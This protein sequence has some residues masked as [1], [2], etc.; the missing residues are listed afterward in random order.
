MKINNKIEKIFSGSRSFVAWL[1]LF[2]G[3]SVIVMNK[4]SIGS[5]LFG[6]SIVLVACFVIFSFSGV[7]I[8]TEKNRVKQYYK[9]IGFIKLGNWQSLNLYSGVTLIPIKKVHGMASLSNRRTTTVKKDYRIYLVNKNKKPAFAIKS[10]EN[11]EDA[12]SSLDEFAIWLK[13]PVF[14]PRKR[15]VIRGKNKNTVVT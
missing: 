9:I 1:F 6:I 4:F 3:I 8:D 5:V 14:S 13:L 10:C 15:P 2:T 7:E 11:P 12:L